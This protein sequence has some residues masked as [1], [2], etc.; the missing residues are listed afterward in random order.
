[1]INVNYLAVLVA[2]IASFVVGMLWYG[3][4]FGKTW[5]KLSGFKKKGHLSAQVSMSIGFVLGLV[6][7][8]VL[9]MF[10]SLFHIV[11]VP[12][13]LTLAFWIWLGFNMPLTAGA[14]IWEGKPFKLFALNTVHSLVSLAIMA[15]IV[16]LWI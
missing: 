9:A 6:N 1:M 3:P 16:A 2:T 8:Y 15:C 14:W 11:N 4:L 13:A 12:G 7:A 5:Q 10:A